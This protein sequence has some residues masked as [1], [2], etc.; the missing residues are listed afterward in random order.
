M[1]F[2][3]IAGAIMMAAL[4]LKIGYVV[5]KNLIRKKKTKNNINL[6]L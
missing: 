1:E 6:N 4:V 3:Y 2:F 5:Y